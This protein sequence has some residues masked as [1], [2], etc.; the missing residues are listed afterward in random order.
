MPSFAIMAQLL[1]LSNSKVETFKPLG[2]LTV[3]YHLNLSKRRL[4]WAKHIYLLHIYLHHLV[5]YS[6]RKNVLNHLYLEL[7]LQV[8]RASWWLYHCS[9]KHFFYVFFDKWVVLCATIGIMQNG[10]VCYFLILSSALRFLDRQKLF[11]SFNI[12]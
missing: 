9:S 12:C 3:R 6:Q 4:F 10:L 11:F 1:S 8:P 2:K 5:F 7:E